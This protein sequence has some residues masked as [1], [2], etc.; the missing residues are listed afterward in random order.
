M[1][2]LSE[3][4]VR[5]VVPND[6]SYLRTVRLVVASIGTDAQYTVDRIEDLK[7]VVDEFVSLAM[8]SAPP[9]APITLGVARVDN[10]IVVRVSA[11][12]G[13]VDP[14]GEPPTLD[15]LSRQIVDALVQSSNRELIDGCLEIAFVVEPSASDP[16]SGA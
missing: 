16:S 14:S 5:L 8:T 10:N 1:R 2:Q 13:S 7:L 6:S 11:P 15:V 3:F 12:L 4:P 9:L